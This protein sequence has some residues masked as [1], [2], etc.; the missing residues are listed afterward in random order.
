MV[1]VLRGIGLFVGNGVY[2]LFVCVL[3]GYVFAIGKKSASRLFS[4]YRDV[5]FFF[6]VACMNE[7][8]CCCYCCC[9]CLLSAC[10]GLRVEE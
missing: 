8:E 7:N 6:L 1:L 2:V 9:C 4:S 5:F 3:G 10:F